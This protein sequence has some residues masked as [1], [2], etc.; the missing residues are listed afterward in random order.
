MDIKGRVLAK[1][2]HKNGTFV[3]IETK[4]SKVQILFKPKIQL[5]KIGD[6]IEANVYE[7]QNNHINKFFIVNNFKVLNECLV[8]NFN[9]KL[10]DFIILQN[11]LVNIIRSNFENIDAIEVSTP[12]LGKFRGTSKIEPF[13]TSL[14]VFCGVVEKHE[15]KGVRDFEDIRK[16]LKLKCLQKLKFEKI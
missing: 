7:E 11:R 3:D 15:E 16:D 8:P 2:N 14:G 9:K 12:T 4:L 10:K 13:K 6:I 1:R 5:P